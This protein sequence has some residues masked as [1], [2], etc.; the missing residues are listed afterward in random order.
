[1]KGFGRPNEIG[2]LVAF[3]L[4]DGASIIDPTVIPFDGSQSAKY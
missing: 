1:M 3:L 2:R 4:S